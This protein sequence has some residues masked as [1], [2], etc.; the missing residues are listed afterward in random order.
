MQRWPNIECWLGSFMIFQGFRT[1]KAKKPYNFVIFQGGGG[2]WTP[3]PPP[4][5]PCMLFCEHTVYQALLPM[6]FADTHSRILSTRLPKP[7][8]GP[9]VKKYVCHLGLLGA[10]WL[11]GRVLDSRSRGCWFEPHWRHCMH[12]LVSLSRTLYPLLSTGYNGGR[13][14]P[15]W[16]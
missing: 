16:L 14:V 5:D 6:F 13:P 2:V 1:S 9:L 3:Y 11:S 8:L 7:C 4:L 10:W 12:W 15:T